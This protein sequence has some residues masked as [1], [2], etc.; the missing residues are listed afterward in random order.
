MAECLEIQDQLKKKQYQI[1]INVKNTKSC[2]VACSSCV[3][4]AFQALYEQKWDI[5]QLKKYIFM[6]SLYDFKFQTLFFFSKKI[7]TGFV[8]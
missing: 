1:L 2:L 4:I 5:K 8:S 3:T 7:P 6:K